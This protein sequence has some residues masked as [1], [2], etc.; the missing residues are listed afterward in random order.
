MR[1][2]QTPLKYYTFNVP[3]KNTFCRIE[4]L[5]EPEEYNCPVIRMR[6]GAPL[7]WT[8]V[9]KKDDAAK[10]Q[11]AINAILGNNI[12]DSVTLE[13]EGRSTWRT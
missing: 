8:L 13:A 11:E 4:V 5:E 9:L 2:K 10:F 1:E 3:T 7:N 6:A 12:L